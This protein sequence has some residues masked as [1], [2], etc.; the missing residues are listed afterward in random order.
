MENPSKRPFESVLEELQKTVK[1][2]ESGALTLEDS[3]AAYERGVQL[4]RSAQADLSAAEKR[5]EILTEKPAT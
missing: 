4:I 5:I 2:L 3:L 1:A